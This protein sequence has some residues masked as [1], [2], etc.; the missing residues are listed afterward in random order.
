MSFR[1]YPVAPCFRF[2]LKEAKNAEKFTNIELAR[3]AFSASVRHPHQFEFT[4]KLYWF[5]RNLHLL[6]TFLTLSVSTYRQARQTDAVTKLE[7]EK[8]RTNALRR[9]SASAKVQTIFGLSD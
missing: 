3:S 4:K 9:P 7:P 8:V 2:A 5:P 6:K 1:V